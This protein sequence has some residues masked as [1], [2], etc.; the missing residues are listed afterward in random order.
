[1]MRIPESGQSDLE[2]AITYND[3]TQTKDNLFIDY[4]FAFSALNL[5]V[6]FGK[7]LDI[8]TGPGWIPVHIAHLNH[9]LEIDAVDPSL[10]MIEVARQNAEKNN[11]SSRVNFSL[12]NALTLP[13]DDGYFDLVICHSVFHHLQQPVKAFNEIYR[14]VKKDGA[15][16]IRDLI[17]PP[18][19]IIPFYVQVFGQPYSSPMKKL[20]TDSLRAAYTLGEI[21]ESLRKSKIQEAKIRRNFITHWT[22]LR[23]SSRKEKASVGKYLPASFFHKL[24]KKFYLIE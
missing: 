5:G 9:H 23:K 10:E 1:M 17:R 21:S 7:M 6:A 22:I 13:F 16:I 8:G 3:L 19:L 12:G 24:M 15:F 11:L 14:V 4:C 20:Y 2:E 18:A